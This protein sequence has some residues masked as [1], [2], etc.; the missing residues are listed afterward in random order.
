MNINTSTNYKSSFQSNIKI[1]TLKDSIHKLLI[2]YSLLFYATNSLLLF[3][4]DLDIVHFYL[5][6]RQDV[7]KI[8]S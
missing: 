3:Y 7:F 1:P 4:I 2:P 6:L 8:K 5:L